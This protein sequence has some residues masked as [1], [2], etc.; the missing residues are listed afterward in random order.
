MCYFSLNAYQATIA[1]VSLARMYTWQPL[2]CVSLAG[3]YTWEPVD[4]VSLAGMYTWQ[5]AVRVGSA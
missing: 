3:M 4:C 2:A 5:P 1:C